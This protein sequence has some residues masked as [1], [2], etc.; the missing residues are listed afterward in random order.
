VLVG[1]VLTIINVS[2]STNSYWEQLS[3]FKQHRSHVHTHY[4]DALEAIINFKTQTLILAGDIS[5]RLSGFREALEKKEFERLPEVMQAHLPLFQLDLGVESLAIYQDQGK[6]VLEWN[7]TYDSEKISALVQDW[8]NKV[9]RTKQPF[10]TIWCTEKC[11]IFAV[12]PILTP[13]A[14]YVVALTQ[15]L[16]DIISRIKGITGVDTGILVPENHKEHELDED[17]KLVKWKMHI[18]ALSGRQYNSQ[19]LHQVAE[20]V[21]IGQLNKSLFQLEVDCQYFEVRALPIDSSLNISSGYWVAIDNITTEI[22]AINK[23]RIKSLIAGTIGLLFSGLLLAFILWS[24]MARLSRIS[25]ILP[26]LAIKFHDTAR[27]CLKKENRTRLLGDDEIDQLYG[28]TLT[29]TKRL[30][31]LEQDVDRNIQALKQ[32][33]D[34]AIN[35]SGTAFTDPTMLPYLHDLLDKTN[36]PPNRIILEITETAAVANLAAAEKMITELRELGCRFSL[37]DFGVGFTSFT[38]LKHLPVDFIKIDGAFVRDLSEQSDDLLLV[39]SLA[40]IAHGLGKKTVAEFV[41]NE[42]SLLILKRLGVDY[43]QGYHIG[44]PEVWDKAVRHLKV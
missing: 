11:S 3:Q 20:H 42:E 14:Q 36:V 21:S 30:E 27:H 2:L 44:K 12:L 10:S 18:H 35:L 22:Q 29:L 26:L 25:K 23:A 8:V 34:F 24:P 13:N 33:R 28:S 16:S 17:A 31:S 1:I 37:D 32:E 4:N 7:S 9:N 40:E 41:E 39:K 5:S 19:V 6:Q 15:P 38:Y 43:A